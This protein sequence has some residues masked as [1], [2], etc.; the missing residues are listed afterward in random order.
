MPIP[1]ARRMHARWVVL[2]LLMVVCG[3]NEGAPTE[4]K[5]TLGWVEKVRIS[6]GEIVLAAKL[7]TGADHSSLH[8][9]QITVFRRAGKKWVTC[10]ID[11]GEGQRVT[12]E[13]PLVR[14]ARIRRHGGSYEERPVVR[15]QVCVKDTLREAEVNLVDRAAME[16]RMLI[17]RSFMK[18]HIVVDP[19]VEFTSEPECGKR[20]K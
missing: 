3:N 11:N 10:V 5:T 15:L 19:S 1:H 8:A 7:D 14:T 16:F 18:D 2:S 12:I 13:L 6:P 20:G 4:T 17:G 9:S